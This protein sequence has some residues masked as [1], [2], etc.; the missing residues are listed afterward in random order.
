MSDQGGLCPV[1]ISLDEVMSDTGVI[2]QPR[3]SPSGQVWGQQPSPNGSVLPEMED[4]SINEGVGSTDDD[5]KY[6]G[7]ETRQ[8]DKK[9]VD[10]GDT[11]ANEAQSSGS[12]I[13]QSTSS[14]SSSSSSAPAPTSTSTPAPA[15][16]PDGPSSQGQGAHGRKCIAEGCNKCSQ[17]GTKFC[18]KHGGKCS[19][20]IQAQGSV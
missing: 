11:G 1:E 15:P 4:N 9:N 6:D 18:I 12:T 17:G 19:T 3:L 2:H 14:S 10:G 5:G 13:K 8:E 7:P 16:A 20:C